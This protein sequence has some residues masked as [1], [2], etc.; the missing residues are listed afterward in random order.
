MKVQ[1]LWCLTD[2]LSLQM[3]TLNPRFVHVQFLPEKVVL[4]QVFLRIVLL[5]H[6]VIIPPVFLT[7]VSSTNDVVDR[8]VILII[9]VPQVIKIK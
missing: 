7:H 1:W 9:I 5:S 6:I 8:V 4:G 3:A 2:G